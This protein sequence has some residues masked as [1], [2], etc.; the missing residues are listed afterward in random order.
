MRPHV[1]SELIKNHCQFTVKRGKNY[2]P[3]YCL[4]APVSTFSGCPS[5]CII[6]N[7]PRQEKRNTEISIPIGTQCQAKYLWAKTRADPRASLTFALID[8]TAALRTGANTRI[9]SNWQNSPGNQTSRCR[10]GFAA[11]IE[12]IKRKGKILAQVCTVIFRFT[13]RLFGL[14]F[15]CPAN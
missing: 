2:G 14:R 9:W 3:H 13:S 12:H 15:F 5:D 6:K 1:H 8:T 4:A 11:E 7:P 10:M